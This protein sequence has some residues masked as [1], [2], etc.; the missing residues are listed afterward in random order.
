[1]SAPQA[2]IRPCSVCG[3]T[4][5]ASR[6]FCQIC[7]EADRTAARHRKLDHDLPPKWDEMQLGALWEHLNDPRCHRIPKSIVDTFEHLMRQ[8]N[9][10][11]LKAWLAERTVAERRALRKLVEK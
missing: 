9:R 2:Q 11:R 6:T 3:C 5:C 4:P 1:M 10:E 8:G 7:R